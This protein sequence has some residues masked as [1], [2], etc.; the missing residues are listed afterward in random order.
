MELSLQEKQ[1]LRQRGKAFLEKCR[2]IMVREKCD[3]IQARR[4]AIQELQ[5]QIVE[6][7]QVA[8]SFPCNS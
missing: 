2:G 1:I 7:K 8:A 4:I 3:L 5:S 6:Q